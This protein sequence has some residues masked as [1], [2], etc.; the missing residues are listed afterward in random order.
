[1]HTRYAPKHTTVRFA[2]AAAECKRVWVVPGQTH[3]AAH[4]KGELLA[5]SLAW[6]ETAIAR[7]ESFPACTSGDKVTAVIGQL[8]KTGY[9]F[10][11]VLHSKAE[12]KE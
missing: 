3:G 9:Y 11:C 1:M 8:V 4:E 7:L 5:V 2:A 12:K 10:K 6:F